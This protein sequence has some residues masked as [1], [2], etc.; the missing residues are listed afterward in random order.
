[1]SEPKL[2]GEK[3]ARVAHSKSRIVEGNVCEVSCDWTDDI[4]RTLCYCCVSFMGLE[5]TDVFSKL[6]LKLCVVH[7]L[8]RQWLLQ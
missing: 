3:K 6:V 7:A 5:F 1:M 2:L 8:F 4:C